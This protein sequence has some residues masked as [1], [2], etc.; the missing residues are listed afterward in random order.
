MTGD[1]RAQL[2]ITTEAVPF[3]NS[4]SAYLFHDPSFSEAISKHSNSPFL[5]NLQSQLI[6]SQFLRWLV[7]MI[8]RRKRCSTA[9]Y[10]QQ[11]LLSF[12][13]SFLKINSELTQKVFAESQVNVRL[14]DSAPRHAFVP[15]ETR[16]RAG[17]PPASATVATDV[18]IGS[19]YSSSK[20]SVLQPNV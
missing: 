1:K 9:R 15:R 8:L 20:L 12:P 3:G 14:V 19:I 17:S 7:S 16:R 10:A 5:Y 6:P 4:D 18:I 13:C 2:K 11:A